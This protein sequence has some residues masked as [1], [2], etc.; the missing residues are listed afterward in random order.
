MLQYYQI[1]HHRNE[2]SRNLEQ[3]VSIE[4]KKKTDHSQALTHKLHDTA[5]EN[6]GQIPPL[7]WGY[8]KVSQALPCFY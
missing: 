4:L 2:F 8:T 7:P 3:G 6:F 1:L 5:E